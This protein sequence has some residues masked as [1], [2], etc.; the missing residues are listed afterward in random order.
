MPGRRGGDGIHPTSP[1]PGLP[2]AIKRVK[3]ARGGTKP[4]KTIVAH[5]DRDVRDVR[6]VRSPLRAGGF[7]SAMNLV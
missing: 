1:F 6:D 4:E 5:A 7:S 3:I 2:P